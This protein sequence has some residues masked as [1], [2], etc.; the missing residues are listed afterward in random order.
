MQGI[1]PVCFAQCMN[2]YLDC[3]YDRLH[4]NLM[5][6]EYIKAGWVSFE[7][8]E[9]QSDQC[10]SPAGGSVFAPRT[11]PFLSLVCVDLFL[12]RSQIRWLVCARTRDLPRPLSEEGRGEKELFWYIFT[13]PLVRSLTF[14]LPFFSSGYHLSRQ[15]LRPDHHF[16]SLCQLPASSCSGLP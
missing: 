12:P 5:C 8:T 11:Q 1:K 3:K 16:G 6:G 4:A 2:A 13:E 9:L 15:G 7:L 14:I 10:D